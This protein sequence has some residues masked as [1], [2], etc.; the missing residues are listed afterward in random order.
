MESTRALVDA[1]TME[2]TEE[3][4]RR[5]QVDETAVDMMDE[6]LYCNGAKEEE[7][8]WE[9][10]TVSFGLKGD[11]YHAELFEA[12]KKEMDFLRSFPVFEA[13]T[14][15]AARAQERAIQVNCALALCEFNAGHK[16]VSFFAPPHATDEAEAFHIYALTNDLDIVYVDFSRAFAM[17]PRSRASFSDWLSV[18]LKL[19]NFRRSRLRPCCFVHEGGADIF[20]VPSAP[21]L[22]KPRWLATPS[23]F[24]L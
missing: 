20:L 11:W 12:R 9:A 5:D 10:P 2:I 6:E 21:T 18:Q 15:E 22:K 3:T 1:N 8:L 4:L 13:W 19:N 23:R 16:D 17:R 7:C 24:S 14:L